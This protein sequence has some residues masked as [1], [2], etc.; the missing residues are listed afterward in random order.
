MTASGQQQ[1]KP[2][3]ADGADELQREI[4]QTREELGGTVEQ[5]VAKADI[6]GR[7]RAK[8][9]GLTGQAKSRASWAA[10]QA[11]TQAAQ[12]RGQLVAGAAQVRQ[13]PVPLALAAVAMATGFVALRW[14]RK[15]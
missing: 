13:R 11:K 12:A 6:K 7:V 8:V 5:L 14:W 3:P 1:G 15:R 9:S 2:V 10:S 4:E